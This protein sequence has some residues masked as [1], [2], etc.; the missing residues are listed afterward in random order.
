M[1]IVVIDGQ[2][3]GLG[4]Q[5]VASIVKSNLEIELIAVGTNSLA[6]SSMIK[7]GAK[8]AATGEN[9]VIVSCRKADIIVG[10]LG[11]AIADSF[12]G[13]ITPAMALAVGQSSA[14]KILIPMNMCDN[15]IAGVQK[16]SISKFVDDTLD[17]IKKLV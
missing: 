10:A 5:L 2:G 16:Q 3:G 13:E 7:S 6:T 8:N 4:K 14:K 15:I 11:I 1:K 17:I 9:A 12:L